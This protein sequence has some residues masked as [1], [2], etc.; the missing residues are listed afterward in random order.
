MNLDL[1][2]LAVLGVVASVLAQAYKLVAAKLGTDTSKKVLMG[3]IS[4]VSIAIGYLW[5]RPQLP[6]M[7]DE[8][9][10]FV[11]ELFSVALSILGS[12]T[13]IY[14]W[15][16]SAVFDKLKLVKETFLPKSVKRFKEYPE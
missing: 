13:V 10:K 6:V 1:L 12:A 14:R 16:L 11:E 3:V 2:Q 7:G 9:L 8:P 15:L 4:V 5:V